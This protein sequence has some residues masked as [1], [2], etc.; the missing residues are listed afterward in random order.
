MKTLR[1]DQ[2]IGIAK[3]R[4]AVGRGERRIVMQGPTGFGKTVVAAD[5][6]ARARA[7][8]KRILVTVPMLSLI[9][10]T[11][12]MLGE[13]NVTDV[14]VIQEGTIKLIRRSRYKWHQCR[15]SRTG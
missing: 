1:S 14:G 4:E 7:K 13:Q 10:Q 9:D 12:Q 15:R 6:I 8:N 11:V 5:M 3:L 2:A